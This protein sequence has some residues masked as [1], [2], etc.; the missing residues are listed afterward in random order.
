MA[1]IYAPNQTYTGVSAT[2]AF[3]DGVGETNDPKLIAWFHA[4]GYTV[5]DHATCKQKE[6][7][8]K[9]R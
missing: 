5:K 4:H 3:A 6:K 1:K 9:Q 8:D 7:P 2:I